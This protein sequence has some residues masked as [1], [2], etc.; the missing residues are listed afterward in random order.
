MLERLMQGHQDA[1]PVMA[2]ASDAATPQPTRVASVGVPET[3]SPAAEEKASAA[4]RAQA[5]EAEQTAASPEQA[6]AAVRSA[7]RRWAKA[8]STQDL[9]AYFAAY[10]DDFDPRGTRTIQQWRALRVRRV[11]RPETIS[12]E[13]SRFDVELTDA[14]TAVVHFDQAYEYNMYQDQERK[15]VT[16]RYGAEDWVD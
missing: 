2:S 13:L 4:P 5:V 14:D 9:D 8:W 11:R 15:T 3:R 16:M 12:I 6:R 7:L 1:A 10:S